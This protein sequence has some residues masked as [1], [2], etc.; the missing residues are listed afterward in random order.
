MFCPLVYSIILR[1]QI[2]RIW[3][4]TK[5]IALSW[6]IHKTSAGELTSAISGPSPWSIT[7]KL[8]RHIDAYHDH[9]ISK[10]E[11]DLSNINED[12]K[13][14]IPTRATGM[15]YYTK[16]R[17][18]LLHDH[19]RGALR[20]QHLQTWRCIVVHCFKPL[21]WKSRSFVYRITKFYGCR[22]FVDIHYVIKK[23]SF[24]I[25]CRPMV[26]AVTKY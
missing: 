12:M 3:K 7:L 13:E 22:S 26:E 24:T 25:Y 6:E 17:D 2:V 16:H 15:L 19:Q 23:M 18:R 9:I 1:Y 14:N 21:W 11:P 5:F 10:G 8:R 4:V 20:L